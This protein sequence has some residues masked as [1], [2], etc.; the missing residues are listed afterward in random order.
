MSGPVRGT[1]VLLGI[2]LVAIGCALAALEIVHR[3]LLRLGRRDPF[4]ADLARRTHRPAR[5]F[6]VVFATYVAANVIPLPREPWAA[7]VLH[8]LD[9]LV[10][11]VS[12]WLFGALLLV[13]EDRTLR[14]FRTD[15][16][17]NQRARRTRTQIQ[18][19]RRV[20][21][22]FIAVIAV[23]TMLVTFPD[24]RTTGRSL[25]FSAGVLGVLAAL[26]SQSLLA[27]ML[28]GI[29][30]AFSGAVRLDDVV[31]VDKHWGRVEEITLSYLVVRIWDD[32]RLVV[33]SSY[34][35]G[36]PF[37]NWTRRESA[38]LGTVE[39]DLD[40]AVPVAEM[41]EELQR[42]VTETQLWD[43]RVSLLQVTDAIGPYVRIRCLVSAADAPTL[44]DLRCL[45]R[46]RL[47]EWVREHRPQSLPRLRADIDGVRPAAFRDLDDFDRSSQNAR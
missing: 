6:A 44:W 14:R 34:F 21:I 5:A 4:P 37:E 26:A 39:I 33:P 10:I 20:T 24:A 16:R 11:A 28:A 38:V 27:N 25:L 9:L 42:V 23:G 8:A 29:Q 31:V 22:A 45:V 15:V 35:A 12:A 18:L 40:W 2:V 3:I 30:L 17:D 13:V 46:E 43:E 19:I 32:R 1:L 41:R 7:P 47:V 36:H